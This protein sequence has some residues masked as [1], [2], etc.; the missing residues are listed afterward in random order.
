M[1]SILITS[2]NDDINL[3]R[4]SHLTLS[5]LKENPHSEISLLTFKDLEGAAQT[6]KHVKEVFYLDRYKIEH[7]KS[8]ALYSDAF[9]LNTLAENLE[10]VLNVEWDQVVNFSNDNI[11]AYLAP[12]LKTKATVGSSVS[13]FGSAVTSDRW[14]SYRNFY[15]SAV[16]EAPIDPVA[17]LH[18]SANIPRLLGG[19]RIRINQDFSMVA[20]QNFARIRAGKTSGDSNATIVGLNLSSSETG[21]FFSLEQLQEIVET[22]ETSLEYKTVLLLRGSPREKELVNELNKLFN[23]A[24]ISI[25]MD[26]SAMPSVLA[27][28]D[29]LVTLPN[30]TAAMAD[31]LDTNVIEVVQPQETP[32]A[33]NEGSFFIKEFSPQQTPDDILF[34]L[35]QENNTILPVNSKNS[36]NK[37][38]AKV[39][40]EFGSFSTLIRG[41]IDINEELEYHVS[42]CFHYA[43]MGYPINEELIKNLKSNATKEAISDFASRANQEMTETVKVL[44]ASLRSLK[45]IGHSDKNAS[46]FIQYLDQL[47][48]AGKKKGPA[49]A[50]ICLF[51]GAVEN[52]S[53]QNSEENLQEIEKSLF[54]LKADLQVLTKIL[55]QLVSEKETT[56]AKETRT[57]NSPSNNSKEA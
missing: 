22:L 11:S 37:V 43:L 41:A 32:K 20:N 6:I 13:L 34:L 3:V 7:L 48:L 55:K 39:K 54:T 44:L 21:A 10:P 45:N 46:K 47:I 56:P 28:L 4:A 30:F 16:Q 42:R 8:G 31:A 35:N 53:S 1:K 5:I 15:C 14:A 25:N 40:D 29:F 52:V 50:A 19:Q 38:Y 9:A 24:L 17:C 2:L 27:N 57:H 26:T 23:N 12:L 33:L 49:Q 36:D 18:H 51:E